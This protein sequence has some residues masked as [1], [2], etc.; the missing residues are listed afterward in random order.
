MSLYHSTS[1]VQAV[2]GTANN[3]L[4]GDEMNASGMEKKR[5]SS[6]SLVDRWRIWRI[7]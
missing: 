5:L 6:I 4:N 1:T 7:S 2:L 3:T